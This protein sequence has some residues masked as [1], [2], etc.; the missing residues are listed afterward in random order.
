MSIEWP[1]VFWFLPFVWVLVV[2]GSLR[3]KWSPWVFGSRLL[4][5]TLLWVAIAGPG[6]WVYSPPAIVVIVDQ[7][8]SMGELTWAHRSA[9]EVRTDPARSWVI[10]FDREPTI[11]A[12]PAQPLAG[13]FQKINE[14]RAESRIRPALEMAKALAFHDEP[15]DVVVISDGRYTDGVHTEDHVAQIMNGHHVRFLR[16]PK[17]AALPELVSCAPQQRQ[18]LP[19][20]TMN[21]LVQLGPG[22]GLVTVDVRL[23]GKSISS[24]PVALGTSSVDVPFKVDI[25]PDRKPGIS[26]LSAHV[27][28]DSRRQ[29]SVG[30]E[31][32]SGLRVLA[33]GSEP[34][35]MGW[36]VEVLQADGVTVD[37][38]SPKEAMSEDL[39]RVGAILLGSMDA[40]RV[41]G[42]SEW[43]QRVEHHVGGGMGLLTLGGQSSYDS[44]RWGLTPLAK[45]L[46]VELET[47]DKLLDGQVSFLAVLDKSGS[48]AYDAGGRPRMAWANAGVVGSLE[49][50]RGSD[51]AGVLAVDDAL[52]WVVPMTSVAAAP[53]FQSVLGIR[54]GSGGIL[55]YS[56]L[57]AARDAMKTEDAP[58]R[59]IVLFVDAQDAEEKVKGKLF[60]W[61][62]GPSALDVA[63]EMSEMGVTVSVIAIGERRDQ[64]VGFLEL[65]ASVGK[66]RFHLTK[67]ASDLVG[68]FAKE[69]RRLVDKRQVPGPIS[70]SQ[71]D[72]ADFLKGVEVESAPPIEHL[73]RTSPKKTASVLWT[74]AE[75][76][77]GLAV[78]RH[79]LGR[80]GALTTGGHWVDSWKRWPGGA[81]FLVQW[82]RWALQS[83]LARQSGLSVTQEGNVL[84]VSWKS[85]EPGAEAVWTRARAQDETE[86]TV[87]L[88]YTGE[89]WWRGEMT[90]QPGEVYRV[91]VVHGASEQVLASRNVGLDVPLE[92][93]R[94]AIQKGEVKSPGVRGTSWWSLRS[95]VLWL[96]FLC[97]VGDAWIWRR[98]RAEYAKR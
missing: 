42:F 12:K 94:P 71:Q 68:L 16:P 10:A 29:C 20:E 83:D 8:E 53:S 56:S 14:R 30:L 15:L 22:T 91:D 31:V 95:A 26:W 63:K 32:E 96:F 75:G 45:M 6:L 88:Q 85:N 3:R 67:N 87:A 23:D 21:F 97:I 86:T 61:A 36:I 72:S 55:M 79:G 43:L 27:S 25:P 39:S 49:H 76:A 11:L 77:L 7:S 58:I 13:V 5:I 48:M 65:L 41:K 89:G 93:T 1:W 19:G 24:V 35:Q 62:P 64:D 47:R 40:V 34:K 28:E 18:V 92:W 60:G 98:V 44:G 38:R 46:P 37:F 84:A 66:G 80:V 2:A 59:H 74:D 9:E 51:R 17:D 78:R 70:L 33:I 69:T 57:V 52:H 73:N 81:Q 54:G 82:T 4:A 90:L 50:L